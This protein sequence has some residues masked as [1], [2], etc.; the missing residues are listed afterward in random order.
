MSKRHNKIWNWIRSDGASLAGSWFSGIVSAAIKGLTKHVLASSP[1]ML[2]GGVVGG[3]L[4]GVLGG[5]GIRKNLSTTAS[6]ELEQS[7]LS[8][9]L[10]EKLAK[11][12]QKS[13]EEFYLKQKAQQNVGHLEEYVVVYEG[14][15]AEAGHYRFKRT[16]N[17]GYLH[18]QIRDFSGGIGVGDT[19]IFRRSRGSYWAVVELI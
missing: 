3:S 10:E 9:R 13:R 6:R 1:A 17:G 7:E 15:N 4:L 11:S 18:A 16:D 14:Y 5:Y 2:V 12:A 8:K 19:L